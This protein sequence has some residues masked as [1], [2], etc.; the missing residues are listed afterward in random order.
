MQYE[1]LMQYTCP[2]QNPKLSN[3]EFASGS[4]NTVGG[5]CG[6]IPPDFISVTT[7]GAGRSA[8]TNDDP[9]RLMYPPAGCTADAS[10]SSTA[11]DCA[12]GACKNS[13]F[14]TRSSPSRSHPMRSYR[15]A[16]C[17]TNAHSTR[18]ATRAAPRSVCS[19]FVRR[20]A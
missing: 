10:P 18:G 19:V 17:K 8:T 4:S 7:A 15:R 1:L 12:A 3:K 20:W 13:Q 6:F 5:P 9:L 14:R 16:L 11:P 2:S